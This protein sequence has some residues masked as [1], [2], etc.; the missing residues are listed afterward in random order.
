[1]LCRWSANS[2]GKQA[3]MAFKSATLHA[4]R[5]K[6]NW[7]WPM[8]PSWCNFNSTQ[9]KQ[10]RR[11]KKKEREPPWIRS[12]TLLWYLLG[13]A[14]ISVERGEYCKRCTIRQPNPFLVPQYPPHLPSPLMTDN[15]EM[16]ARHDRHQFNGNCIVF[17]WGNF[18][19][20]S[21]IRKKWVCAAQRS[22]H[23]VDVVV[24]MKKNC[25]ALCLACTTFQRQV[26]GAKLVVR[27]WHM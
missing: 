6:N 20:R 18:H 10:K 17:S 23:Y 15:V 2:S 24:D 5:K 26:R 16:G 13:T 4:S 21:N 25:A 7:K 9:L 22:T 1:M 11:R 12:P 19:L 14:F 8:S 27:S 3:F